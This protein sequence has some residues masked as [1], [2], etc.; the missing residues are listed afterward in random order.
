MTNTSKMEEFKVSFD[1]K[2][3]IQELLDSCLESQ[4]AVRRCIH[5]GIGLDCPNLQLSLAEPIF[6][7]QDSDSALK[8]KYNLDI[9]LSL[10]L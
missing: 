6:S 8:E 9:I 3:W 1:S 4:L 5:G 7:P 10:D 2:K